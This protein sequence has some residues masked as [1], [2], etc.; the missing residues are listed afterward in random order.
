M[1]LRENCVREDTRCVVEKY[2]DGKRESLPMPGSPTENNHRM[3]Q[4]ESPRL[5]RQS[6]RLSSAGFAR[7]AGAPYKAQGFLR[8]EENWR[9]CV[10][11]RVLKQAPWRG[12]ILGSVSMTQPVET[13]TEACSHAL[14]GVLLQNRHPIAFESQ[15]KSA[16]EGNYTMFEEETLAI[17]HS[18]RDGRRGSHR[19]TFVKEMN[20]DVACHFGTRPNLSSNQA[21]RRR[22]MPKPD[23]ESERKKSNR[24]VPHVSARTQA[25]QA[26]VPMRDASTE[27]TKENS[28]AHDGRSSTKAGQLAQRN[29]GRSLEATQPGVTAMKKSSTEGSPT[30]SVGDGQYVLSRPVDFS[31]MKEPQTRNLAKKWKRRLDTVRANLE[32][33]SKRL[34]RWADGKHRPLDLHVEGQDIVTPRPE[35]MRFLKIRRSSPRE[36]TRGINRS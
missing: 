30:M 15:K 16:T 22:V 36:S 2:G 12:P 35:L 20:N 28:V 24:G 29:G 14:S 26:D 32:I 27:S 9:L 10:N 6:K 18:L 34:R 11:N 17:A 7:P 31:C 25:C 8:E 1:Q 33:V 19:L 4:S 21:R 5:W 23:F 13:Y 3:A